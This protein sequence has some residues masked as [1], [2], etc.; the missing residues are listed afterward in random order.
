MSADH[1]KSQSP[2]LRF[3]SRFPR[4]GKLLIVTHDHP[5]PDSI[6]SAAALSEIASNLARA[7]TTIAYGGVIGRAENAYMVKHLDLKLKPIDRIDLSGYDRIAMV[8]TQPQAGNNALPSGV[9]AD[10][11]IDHHPL[12]KATRKAVC[13]D[14]RTEYGALASVMTEYLFKLDIKVSTGLATA[15]LYGI[16]SE[17]QDL[18]RGAYPVDI[19]CYLKLFPLANKRALSKIVNS[20]VPRDY[21]HY[22]KRAIQHS[23]VAGNAVITRLPE[24]PNPDIIS[25][26]ADLM[27][28]LEGAAWAFCSGYYKGAVYLSVRTTNVRKN[29]GSLMSHIV[30]PR[31]TGGGHCLMAGGKVDSPSLGLPQLHKLQGQL[32][33][34][35]LALIHKDHHSRSPLT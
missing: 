22:L 18:G 32:E 34:K 7:K 1:K 23:Q 30:R 28:R 12:I 19:E 15:L 35:F 3:F 27:L 25:E 9:I 21:F 5:D 4:G 20:R 2:L 17:T 26:F 14:I 8:D 13:A 31:G 16:K 6:S 29:A 33:N 10:L 11:V 24:V